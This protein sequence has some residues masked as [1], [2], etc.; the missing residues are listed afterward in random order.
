MANIEGRFLHGSTMS[1]VTRMTMTGMLGITFV[2]LVDAANLF[3]ISLLGDQSLVAALGFAW[4]VQFFS[5]SSGIGLMIGATALVAR[6]IGAGDR[7]RARALATG[8][9]VMAESI[10]IVVAAIIVTFRHDLVALAGAQGHTADAAARY[11][12]ISVPS[13]PIMALGMVGSAILRAEGDAYRAM[14]VTMASG[15]LSMVADPILIFWLGLGLDGAAI[16][17]GVARVVSLAIALHGVIV[18]HGLMGRP[19]LAALRAVAMPYVAIAAPAVIT[20]LST[21]FGNAVVTRA[22]AGFGDE[23]VAGWAVVVRLTVL[24]FGGIFALS[25][26][27]GGI[28]GQN[29]GAG[30]LDRVQSTYRDAI[31]FCLAY[32]LIAWALLAALTSQVVALFGLH[33]DALHVLVAFTWIGA[34]GFVF[35]GA[36]FVANTAYNN[37][38]R[39]MMATALNWSRDGIFMIPFVTLMAGSL[40]APGAVYGSAIANLCA[41][42][43]AG[44]LGYRFVRSLRDGTDVKAAPRRKA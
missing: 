38:G 40:G 30:K 7:E 20:Q 15:A 16:N 28:F 42:S 29:F 39:P 14:F 41:G 5:I 2:F 27:V 6:A 10:Q 22:I 11:L 25:G 3:W 8:S 18:V 37:L 1:H 24:A 32:T 23:A 19:S 33:G 26:A 34:G 31:L 43:L 12:M 13:L 21:P 35:T 44:W 9:A 17:V 4:T 36:L